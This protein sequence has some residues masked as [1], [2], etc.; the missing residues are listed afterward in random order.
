MVFSHELRRGMDES[1]AKAAVTVRGRLP[2][3]S[4]S[5]PEHLL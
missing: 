5:W 3:E 2:A 1:W 4:E